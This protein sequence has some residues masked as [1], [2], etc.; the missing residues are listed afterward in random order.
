[1]IKIKGVADISCCRIKKITGNY[2]IHPVQSLSN[3][4]A[5][6]STCF[7]EEPTNFVNI[8]F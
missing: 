3:E 4:A 5:I 8:I 2:I 6:F 7:G 1:M